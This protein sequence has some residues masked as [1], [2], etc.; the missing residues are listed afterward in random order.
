M[1]D[2]D[3][4]IESTIQKWSAEGV[5]YQRGAVWF[6]VQ[7][8]ENF[9]GVLL[10]DDLKEFFLRVNGMANWEWDKDQVSFW[11]L[12]SED[13]MLHNKDPVPHVSPLSKVW[14]PGPWPEDLFVIGD[15]SILCFVFCARL[16][17]ETSS[18][19]KVY[20]CNGEEPVVVANSFEE[21]LRSYVR[22]GVHALLPK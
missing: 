22:Q 3:Q 18:A 20:F 11:P 21:F 4:T 12:P 7:L 10:P 8:F 1:C 17:Q 13:E 19:T 5:C 2:L 15:Y 6:E 16:N 9:Y 14:E